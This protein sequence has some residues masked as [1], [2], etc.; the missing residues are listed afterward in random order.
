MAV[1]NAKAI[2]DGAKNEGRPT[3]RDERDRADGFVA[4]AKE[5]REEVEGLSRLGKAETAIVNG[6][7]PDAGGKDVYGKFLAK[8]FV[9]GKVAAS[10]PFDSFGRKAFSEVT[11]LDD[12]NRGRRVD[13]PEPADR[14]F[15]YPA[16][17]M[18]PVPEGQT[19]VEVLRGGPRTLA[20]PANMV[21]AIDAVTGKPVTSSAR[22]LASASMS[23]VAT[24]SDPI[25]RISV[26]NGAGDLVRTDLRLAFELSLD[27]MVLDALEA[28]GIPATTGA[29]LAHTLANAVEALSAEGYSADTLI[30]RPITMTA[31]SLYQTAGPEEMFASLPIPA[32]LR[33]R[34]SS[35]AAS[36]FVVDSSAAA[37]LFASP[38]RLDSDESG[39]NFESNTVVFRLENHAHFEVLRAEAIA[40][41]TGGS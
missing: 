5:I 8:G 24:I 18:T 27:S 37:R 20:S 21:R 19:S 36:D 38:V 14:R 40:K 6:T 2:Y 13:S 17:P 26:A 25:P 30:L 15:A 1:A 23:Q 39:D 33:I 4:R 9:P 31:I 35:N 10:I 28:D 12:L 3:T 34:I 22:E 32:G 29:T 16:F 11:T 7:S 41:I